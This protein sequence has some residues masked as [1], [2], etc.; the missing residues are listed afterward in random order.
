MHADENR[1]AEKPIPDSGRLV[2]ALI[3]VDRRASAVSTALARPGQE[4]PK[5]KA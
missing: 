3:G 5:C 4:W 1:K 2:L